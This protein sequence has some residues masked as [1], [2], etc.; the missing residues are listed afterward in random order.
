MDGILDLM[1]LILL[2]LLRY[3]IKLDNFYSQKLKLSE[4]WPIY[5]YCEQYN[6]ST[7]YVFTSIVLQGYTIS[8][9]Y[10]SILLSK[11]IMVLEI[12]IGI[13]LDGQKIE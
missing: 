5:I 6:Y 8:S 10:Y 9:S 12:G 1:N 2:L 11:I 3:D 7:I 4:E 13:K